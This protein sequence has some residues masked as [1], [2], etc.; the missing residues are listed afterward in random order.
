MSQLMQKR[1]SHTSVVAFTI[2]L[3]DLTL[4]NQSNKKMPIQAM[5]EYYQ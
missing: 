5:R 4:Q 3:S 1:T 2:E